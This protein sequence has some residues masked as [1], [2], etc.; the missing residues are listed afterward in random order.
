MGGGRAGGSCAVLCCA[1]L[2]CVVQCCAVQ[3][4]A[5]LCSVVLCCAVVSCDGVTCRA[6][7][8]EAGPA[9]ALASGLLRSRLAFLDGSVNSWTSLARRTGRGVAHGSEQLT[10]TPGTEGGTS[11]SCGP[12]QTRLFVRKTTCIAFRRGSPNTLACTSAVA[13]MNAQAAAAEEL[14]RTD[15]RLVFHVH[16]AGRF[17]ILHRHPRILRS[18]TTRV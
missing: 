14:A 8:A 4:C 12:F 11:Q 6:D 13:T 5:V 17:N 7:G 2:C 3:C 16:L 1:V 18:K 15:Y 10:T 9:G